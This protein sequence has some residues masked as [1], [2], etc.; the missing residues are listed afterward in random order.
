MG[1]WD[2]LLGGLEVGGIWTIERGK[3]RHE[4]SSGLSSC[5]CVMKI[6]R[7]GGSRY[8]GRKYVRCSVHWMGWDSTARRMSVW[9]KCS[10]E[11]SWKANCP[12][13]M[14]TGLDTSRRYGKQ[15]FVDPYGTSN[16]TSRCFQNIALL[17]CTSVLGRVYAIKAG[18]SCTK[19]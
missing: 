6:G 7:L 9:I 5:C 13:S 18:V 16:V 15:S 10:V 3:K 12:L 19:L 1:I 8:G 17:P 4:L 11:S 14:W 2:E